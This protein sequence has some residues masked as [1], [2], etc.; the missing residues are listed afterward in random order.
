MKKFIIP[1]L[2]SIFLT[3]TTMVKAEETITEQQK[4]IPENKGV[5]IIELPEQ[6]KNVNSAP[7]SILSKEKNGLNILPGEQNVLIKTKSLDNVPTFPPKT[8]LNFQHKYYIP[9]EGTAEWISEGLKNKNEGIMWE[10]CWDDLTINRPGDSWNDLSK[11][12]NF[13]FATTVSALGVIY[14]KHFDGLI[15]EDRG[16]AFII[17]AVIMTL[18]ELSTLS[19][20]DHFCAKDFAAG[21]AGAACGSFVITIGFGF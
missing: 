15:L 20:K 19:P 10:S 14:F 9:G 6:K 18:I 21:L 2:L 1:V 17:T 4:Q 8:R 12:F 13:Q 3:A 11:V 7:N 5:I 16:K